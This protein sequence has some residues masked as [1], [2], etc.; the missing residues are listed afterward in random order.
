[1][2]QWT[3]ARGATLLSN[4]IAT[5]LGTTAYEIRQKP[6][7]GRGTTEL[8]SSAPRPWAGEV[9]PVRSIARYI[10]HGATCDTPRRLAANQQLEDAG[11]SS[12]RRLLP[13]MRRR[14]PDVF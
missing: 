12:Y 4:N 8:P 7:F 1:V 13:V 14:F 9:L 2:V 5:R 11:F 3:C 10:M 6:L